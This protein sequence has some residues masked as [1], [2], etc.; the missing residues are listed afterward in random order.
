[1]ALPYT[2]HLGYRQHSMA[3]KPRHRS[4]TVDRV[5]R[6]PLDWTLPPERAALL[7]R[8]DPYPF[9]LIGRWAGGGAL[10]GSDPIKT[11]S[12]DGDPSSLLD[13]QP[14]VSDDRAPDAVGGGW[15]GWLGY[16]LGRRLEPVDPSPPPFAEHPPFQLAFY[17]HLLRLDADGR[18]WF[19]ALWSERRGDALA[20][21]LRDL[22]R[23]AATPPEPRPFSTDPWRA[24]PTSAGHALAVEACRERIHAGDLFQANVCVRLDSRICGQ[25]IDLFAAAVRRLEPDR[26]A[27]FSS[28]LGAVASLSP[29][30]FLERHGRHVRSA[31]IKGTRAKAREP[32]MAALA[33]EELLDSE[34]DRAENVMIVDLVRNDL[35]RVCVPGSVAVDALAQA[36]AHAGVWHL[37]SEV[38]GTLREGVGDSALVRA[39][40]P[41]GSVSGAP[42]IAAMNVVA[43][44]ESTARELYTGAIGFASPLAGLELSVAIRT[45]EFRG[46]AAWLGV[47]GGI[48]A[49]SDPAAE[50]AECTVKAAPLLEAIG[51]TLAMA[52][53]RL[54]G[55]PPLLRLG[56]HPVPRPDAAAGVF[57]TMLVRDRRP[58]FLEQHLRRLGASIAVLYG[59][60]LPVGLEQELLAAAWELDGGRLRVDLRPAARGI[61]A[62][63]VVSPLPA[64]ASPVTLC[65]VTIPGGLG[66]HKWSD[67]RLL[68]ALNERVAGDPLLVDL[69]GRVLESARASVFMVEHAA[70]LLT[71][72]ADGRILPGVTR[73]RVIELARAIGLEVREEAVELGQMA[74]AAEVFVTGALAGVERAILED[75]AGSTA[76]VTASLA[77]AWAASLPD[78]PTPAPEIAA[79]P[80]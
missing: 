49:D 64:R 58:V 68:Q 32:A 75:G 72:P 52:P 16:P 28:P 71:P 11:A 4:T 63:I 65:P 41:P 9:A 55:S 47:G 60:V 46:E 23:R 80:A 25:P 36:R 77:R 24:T 69:D 61:A 29:E 18:W 57:E 34:K 12:R 33:R 59:A 66:C 43:E 13:D 3:V 7:V 79:L 19:E 8:D 70:R 1:M 5:T 27:F 35:G 6:T 53:R 73:S 14:P 76:P 39:A 38:S 67:R 37:V 48:V 2:L 22:E 31:P 50:A 21:R 42:K 74:H 30:L 45:F 62:E 44:L 26:A 56:P 78:S 17:D 10:I 51:G 54:R 40:F 15:F 20:L